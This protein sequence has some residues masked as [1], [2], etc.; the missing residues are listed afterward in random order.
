LRRAIAWVVDLD[1]RTCFVAMA[2]RDRRFEGRFFIAVR[3]TKIYCRPGC[4]AP[5]PLR[6]NV[7]FYPCA[8]A[9]EEAGYRPCARCRPDALPDTSAG[10]GT[11]ATVRRALRLI[12]DEG[13]GEEGVE[14]L[15]E[16]LGIGARHL[17]RLFSEHVGASPL[18]V[19]QTRRLHFARKLLDETSL[20]VSDVAFASGFSS[21]RRFNDAVRQT[22]R[23]S[24]TELR[25]RRALSP[26]NPGGREA[27]TLRVPFSP[28]YDFKQILAFLRAR[29]IPG[30][31]VVE[32][33]SYRRTLSTSAGP[34]M[35]E[36]KAARDPKRADAEWLELS[37]WGVPPRDLFSLTE[38]VRRLF[39]VA[40]D[41]K[42]IRAHLA[43]D[44]TLRKL[45]QARPGLR[46]PGAWDGFE[47]A[48]RAILGQQV[49]V[50]GATTLSGRLVTRFGERIATA[51]LP[52]PQSRHGEL[53][54]LFP[55]PEALV[56]AHVEAIGIPGAR[57]SAIRALARAVVAGKITFGGHVDLDAAVEALVALPGVGPWTANYIAMRAL[58]EP[59]AILAS[60]RVLRRAIVPG[61]SLTAPEVLERAEA[62][63]PWRAYAVMHFWTHASESKPN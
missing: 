58:R 2:S 23:T 45:V 47:V 52:L 32:R 29:A 15:A 28:P 4:P 1:D 31:E 11:S 22:F 42:A 34:R 61:R 10:L 44:P 37:L 19:A 18:A 63:R 41:P 62:W 56:D 43:S 7:S 17:R 46:V 26:S 36:V 50:A 27:L 51:T 21:V 25:R 9:A 49:S 60:D 59:D 40:V 55:L 30:V 38:R 20:A 35:L 54:H 33:A 3:T 12:A 14:A 13:L 6:K 39:D 24:P 57:A 48:V 53:S 16:R 8:A 5:V